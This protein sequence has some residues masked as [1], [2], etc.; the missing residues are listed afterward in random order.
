MNDEIS[1]LKVK[2]MFIFLNGRSSNVAC[3]T[4]NS[5]AAVAEL[6]SKINRFSSIKLMESLV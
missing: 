3:T 1:Y 4:K 2:Q 6:A 5:L